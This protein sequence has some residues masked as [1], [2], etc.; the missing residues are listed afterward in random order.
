VGWV[1]LSMNSLIPAAFLTAAGKCR[2]GAA[3][4]NPSLGTAQQSVPTPRKALKHTKGPWKY[5][6]VRKG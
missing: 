6:L 1:F 3:C 4:E 5:E 2:A